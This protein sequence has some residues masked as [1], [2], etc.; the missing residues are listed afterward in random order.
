M[1]TT[2]LFQRQANKWDLFLKKHNDSAPETSQNKI[3][4]AGR[5]SFKRMRQWM[6]EEAAPTTVV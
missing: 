3:N 4:L 5:T 2:K 6:Q 1:A